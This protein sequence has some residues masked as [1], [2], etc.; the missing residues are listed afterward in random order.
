MVLMS[1]PFLLV[2]YL[3]V[4]VSVCLW[5]VLLFYLLAHLST[6]LFYWYCI[7]VV[8]VYDVSVVC[9]IYLCMVL[10]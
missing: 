1:T 6:I 4:C 7:S 2:I 10:V 8:C 5:Y 9:A 3:T